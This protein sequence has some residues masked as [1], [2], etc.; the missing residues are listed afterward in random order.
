VGA[1]TTVTISATLNGAS[2][3]ATLTITP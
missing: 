2:V 1:N 3:T